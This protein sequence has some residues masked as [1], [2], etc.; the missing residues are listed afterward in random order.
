MTTKARLASE[1]QTK[2]KLKKAQSTLIM[3]EPLH[4]LRMAHNCL[5]EAYV[6]KS[7]RRQELNIPI[8]KFILNRSISC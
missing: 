3:V 5:P 6:S 1:I 8:V 7:T 4:L 2:L